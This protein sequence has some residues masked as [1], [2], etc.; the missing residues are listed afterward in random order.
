MVLL[1]S[2][3]LLVVKQTFK[4]CRTS[5]EFPTLFFT[6]AS[7][8]P[9]LLAVE[10]YRVNLDVYNGPVDLLLYLIR[11]DELDIYDIPIAH[12]TEQYCKYVELL[13][14]LDPDLVGDFLVMAA[15]L[16]EIK[17]RMLLPTP[18]PEEQGLEQGLAGDPRAELI[19]QLLQYKAFKD[20]AEQLRQSAEQQ[21][22]RFPRGPVRPDFKK[23]ELDLEDVQIWRLLEAFSGLMA[24]IGK[25]PGSHE[26]VYDDTPISLHAEDI[27][28]RLSRDGNM[29]FREIFA[30]RQK[31]TEIVGLF[32]AV[33]ELIRQKRL[34][35]QQEKMFGEI[36]IMLR[37][38]EMEDPTL[39]AEAAEDSAAVSEAPQQPAAP[40][41]E[42][43]QYIA[44][45]EELPGDDLLGKKL[46]GEDLAESP[47]I[48]P[49]DDGFFDPDR[50]SKE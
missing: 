22:M 17:S 25:G 2:L 27:M 43:G 30:G 8:S 29:T 48:P 15:T 21:A 31:R 19:R 20:A 3:V 40:A 49:E 32:L 37:T 47:T 11:R 1:V 7:L 6:S 26:V 34:I 36:Y 42:A 10:P 33:L 5:R 13:R 45:D 9:R 14:E 46:P 38:E 16:L 41:A 39:P 12:I 35:V 44:E 50:D 4:V 23:D 18:P 24:S 28:D